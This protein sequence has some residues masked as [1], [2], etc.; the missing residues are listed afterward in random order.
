MT[1]A[2]MRRQQQVVDQLEQQEAQDILAG[3][4]AQPSTRMVRR[5]GRM[6][7]REGN[8][9]RPEFSPRGYLEQKGSLEPLEDLTS[10]QQ[11]SLPQVIDQKINAVESGEDQM[12]GRVVK[13]IN[14]ADPWGEATVPPSAIN[15]QSPTLLLPPQA[16]SLRE[17]AQNFLQKRFEELG[18]KV[19]GRYR[20]ERLMGQDPQIAEA[21][22]LYASTGDPSVLSRLSETPSSP[23]T[24]TPRIQTEVKDADTIPTRMFYQATGKEEFIDDL[25]EKDINLTNR[26]SE[27]SLAKQN[28]LQRLKEIDEL[29]PQLRFAGADEPEQGGY[30]TRMLNKILSEK[31]NLDPEFFNADLNDA[32]AERNFVRSQMESSQ[33]LGPKY[34]LTQR[35]EGVRPF[36]EVDPVTNE[37]IPETLELRTGRRTVQSEEEK[38]GGGRNYAMYDP[39]SQTGSSVGIYGIEPRNYPI[40]DPELRPTVLQREETKVPLRRMP[41]EGPALKTYIEETKR[42]RAATPQIKQRS[43]EVSEAL[44]R[45]RIEG[46][47]PNMVLRNL[48]FNL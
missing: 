21:M 32:L 19:P 39:E 18:D 30:Y 28:T 43:I 31:Q 17:E 36:F 11:Q 34:K 27:L 47:D 14:A 23:L 12:T 16:T 5:H 10:V 46:R 33:A 4:A 7:P 22:E 37:P 25:F 24:V 2:E 9:Q 13:Q 6:V 41:T 40:A 1:Q 35:Q 26:I 45:A 48:G 38:T 44:R 29:E 3:L 8:L 20:R 15:E 42:A